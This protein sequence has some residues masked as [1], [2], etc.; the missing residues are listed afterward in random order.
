MSGSLMHIV[1][2]TIRNAEEVDAK[3]KVQSG[4][5]PCRRG[6]ESVAIASQVAQATID[7]M[8]QGRRERPTTVKSPSRQLALAALRNFKMAD[9]RCIGAVL[10]RSLP[11]IP[12]AEQLNHRA[13][14]VAALY[15][16]IR[17]N[18]EPDHRVSVVIDSL[19]QDGFEVLCQTLLNIGASR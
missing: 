18:G 3:R 13:R 12:E 2:D 8:A 16:M 7:S 1:G 6:A 11:V 19:E 15:N 9:G 14:C 10:I 17:D 5:N 4:Q